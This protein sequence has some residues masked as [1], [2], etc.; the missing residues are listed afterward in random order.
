MFV[1]LISTKYFVSVN[2]VESYSFSGSDFKGLSAGGASSTVR[3]YIIFSTA[4]T[5]VSGYSKLN[6][7]ILAGY[8]EA[9][10]GAALAV[11]SSLV[12]IHSKNQIFLNF[13]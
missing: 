2:S 10:G 1:L 6:K 9:G 12:L 13:N 7:W 11:S 4:F 8:S 5:S 3:F